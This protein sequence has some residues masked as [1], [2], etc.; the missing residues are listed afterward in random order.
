MIDLVCDDEL[1]AFYQSL[2]VRRATA[3]VIRDRQAQGGRR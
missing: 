3:M 2:G 1:V